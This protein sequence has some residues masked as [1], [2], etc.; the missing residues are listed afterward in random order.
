M[1][2]MIDTREQI[3]DAAQAL[4]Q[5]R[6]YDAFSYAD[7]ASAI[8]IR[9]AS[10][11][12]HFPTKGDLGL[13]LVERFRAACRARLAEVD[14]STPDPRRRLERYAE[15]YA[16]TLAD[17]NRMCLCGM[18][19][20]GFARLAADVREGLVAAFAD[21]EAWL[22]GVLVAG[23][24][25]RRFRTDRPPEELARALISGLEGAMLLARLHGDPARF[26]AESWALLNALE[27]QGT[28]RPLRAPRASSA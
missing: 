17:G 12:H 9:K 15:M 23:R 3:L 19:A 16:E 27:P 25:S 14:R 11:H 7:I 8:G 2:E 13:R 21:Q 1:A 28:P 18:L 6:G 10:I 4:V 20:A 22:A 5:T 24:E 26:R